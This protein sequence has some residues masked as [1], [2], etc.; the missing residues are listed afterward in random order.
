MKF[1]SGF[2]VQIIFKKIGAKTILSNLK[3]LDVGEGSAEEKLKKY[4]PEII[5][6]VVEILIDNLSDVREEI[7]TLLI[8]ETGFS[9]D[10]LIE[11]DIKE[12]FLLL[13]DIF[14][15]GIPSFVLDNLKK[16][17]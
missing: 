5:K 9:K 6:I 10:E 3:L 1:D 12:V 15:D 2:D 14:K 11:M 13:K 4:F 8:K 17:L 7:Y 16:T